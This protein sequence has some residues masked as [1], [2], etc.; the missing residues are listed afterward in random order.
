MKG[1]TLTLAFGKYGGFYAKASS[2]D[3][4]ICLGWAAFTIYFVDLEEFIL[5]LKEKN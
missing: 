2:V 1:L 4:R 5:R 3:W